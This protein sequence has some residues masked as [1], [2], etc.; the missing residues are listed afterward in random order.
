MQDLQNNDP[1][2][3]AIVGDII[4]Q[5]EDPFKDAI[6]GDAISTKTVS[7]EDPFKDAIVKNNEVDFDEET[8]TYEAFQQSP[9]L[10]E[11]AIR[12]AKERLG[13]ENPTSERAID[14]VIEHFRD[15]NVNEL[16]A[17]GEWN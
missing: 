2:K 7:D 1:F 11:A 16:T 10:R 4:P 12:F 6:V 14:E 17:A 13:F 15:F 9:Q 3:D 8:F 5:E